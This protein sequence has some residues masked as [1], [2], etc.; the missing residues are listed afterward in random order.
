M[1]RKCDEEEE[2]NAAIQPLTLQKVKDVFPLDRIEVFFNVKLEKKCGRLALV[3]PASKVSHMHEIIMNA[4][5]F[6]ESTLG[7][8]DKSI[9]VGG[10]PQGENFGNDLG[11]GVNQTNRPVIGNAFLTLLLGQ[12]HNIGGVEPLK[13]G[14]VEGVEAVN[15]PH[16]VVFGKSPTLFEEQSGETVRSGGLVTR[17][18]LDC[19]QNLLLSDWAIELMQIMRLDV[20]LIQIKIRDG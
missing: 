16:D 2:S 20:E 9:H 10:Q 11:D 17:H 18:F 3:K 4:P 7:V 5:S 12:E 19:R 8:G 1:R 6:Y 13:V 14:R 15:D